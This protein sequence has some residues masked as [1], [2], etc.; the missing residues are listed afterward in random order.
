MPKFIYL[1]DH[2]VMFEYKDIKH[3]IV[4]FENKSVQILEL[5]SS[6]TATCCFELD[7]KES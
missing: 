5:D 2:V 7:F 4:A 6:G 1:I 3:L